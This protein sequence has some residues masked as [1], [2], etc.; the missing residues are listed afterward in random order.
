M[1]VKIDLI[2]GDT[3]GREKVKVSPGDDMRLN[4]KMMPDSDDSTTLHILSVD[5]RVQLL[6]DNRDGDISLDN[7]LKKSYSEAYIRGIEFNDALK[8]N[9]DRR[10]DSLKNFN[11]FF[12]TNAYVRAKDIHCESLV[13]GLAAPNLDERI[14]GDDHENEILPTVPASE[15]PNI[16]RKDFPET[17]I[18]KDVNAYDFNDNQYSL[19]TQSPHSITSFTVN[20][21]T[22][23]PE[24]GLGLSNEASF[25]VMQEFFIKLF[26]PYSIHVGET[27][28]I[29]A[30]VYNFIKRDAYEINVDVTMKMEKLNNEGKFEFVKLVPDEKNC[31]VV[32]LY[33]ESVTKAITIKENTGES[34]SFYIRATEAGRVKIRIEA[35]TKEYKDAIIK[36]LII[37][38]AGMSETINSAYFVDLSNSNQ[39]DS[40]EFQCHIGHNYV[41]NSLH[42]SA[43]VYG[44]L[45]GQALVN[46]ENLI[47]M[48][49]GCSEQTFMTWIPNI[50]A[51][52]YIM[53]SENRTN[54]RSKSLKRIKN[55]ISSGYQRMMARSLFKEDGSFGIWADGGESNIWVTAYMVKLLGKARRVISIKDKHIKESLEFLVKHQKDDGRFEC[56]SHISHYSSNDAGTSIPLTSFVINSFIDENGYVDKSIQ[57]KNVVQRGIDYILANF[58]KI[59][60]NFESAIA[61]YTI[62]SYNTHFKTD[63]TDKL[64]YGMLDDLLS[65]A[66]ETNNEIFWFIKRGNTSNEEFSS[67]HIE[68]ASY[69]LMAFRRT[70]RK[71]K[72]KYIQAA[73]KVMKWLM[74]RK[75]SNGGFESSY[76]TGEFFMLFITNI[77]NNEFS[78]RS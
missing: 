61:A 69:A 62:A 18:F 66:R 75:N 27:L 43:T 67:V 59:S 1:Q 70:D 20:A 34:S 38:H 8:N 30:A 36:E 46:T 41:K 7:L 76:D 57:N 2:V 42:M 56:V 49:D 31:K 3:Y 78:P 52:D 72:P 51:Y 35:S 54:N 45:L 15:R 19:A 32:S 4:F 29:E 33:T 6:S 24:H 23:H 37:Q 68:I 44:N 28:K 17:F 14:F 63:K 22:F 21:F 58:S 5:Q 77:V 73:F 40:N 11:A 71:A 74:S 48:P 47:Q 64:L 50:A 26:L 13:Q 39:H 55:A 53:A 25:T 16:I 12:I 9:V 65:N 10:Y 60:N